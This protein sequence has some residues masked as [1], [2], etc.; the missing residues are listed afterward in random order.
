MRDINAFWY[1][2][3]LGPVHAA[4][5]RSFL[6]FGYRV[7]LHV[8]D[9]P[10]DVPEGVELFDAET[11]L[12][13]ADARPHKRS[14]SY[15]FASDIYRYRI[16]QAGLGV[17]VDCD[18][19]C[20][21]PLPDTSYL[22]GFEKEGRLNGAVLGAPADSEFVSYLNGVTR[23]RAFVPPWEKKKKR[24][25]LGIRAKLGLSIDPSSLPWGAFGPAL[26]THAAQ[27]LGLMGEAQ[28]IDV[29]YP[30]HY[31][32]LSLLTEPDLSLSDIVTA[33]TTAIHLYNHKMSAAD[34]PENS[35][36]GE[37]LRA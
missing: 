8:Y 26:V 34:I 31:D 2:P 20:V 30:L 22:F 25:K 16:L 7:R 32:H 14:G 3:R 29:F 33:R 4:C 9:P 1:G 28:P 27:T 6:K 18:V 23:L 17:Y 21:K 10:E 13:R 24:M 11:L 19:F 36:L 12:P 37:I 5:L 15:A 35:P